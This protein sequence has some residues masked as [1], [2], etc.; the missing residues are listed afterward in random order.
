M[1]AFSNLE[2][3]SSSCVMDVLFFDRFGLFGVELEN[4]TSTDL[5]DLFLDSLVVFSSGHGVTFR[6]K[7]FRESVDLRTLID[8]L[9]GR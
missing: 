5:I 6:W 3:C 1:I 9:G 8:S 2:A 4:S 7:A